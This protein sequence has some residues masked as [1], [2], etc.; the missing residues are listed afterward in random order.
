MSYSNEWIAPVA[1]LG[2]IVLLLAPVLGP[3]IGLTVVLLAAG[4]AVASVFAALLA[5]GR[6]LFAAAQVLG[7]R[8]RRSGRQRTSGVELAGEIT[9]QPL[10]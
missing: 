10:R 4:S 3:L 9:A 6:A 7:R 2:L 8:Y 5:L 1:A